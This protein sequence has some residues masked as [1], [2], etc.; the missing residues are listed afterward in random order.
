MKY[1]PF[2]QNKVSDIYEDKNYI[3][4]KKDKLKIIKYNKKNI[5]LENAR[6]NGLF[7]SIVMNNENIV[8]F[9]PQ[10]SVNY[11]NFIVEN[12]FEDC[13]ITEYID[14]TMINIF[15]NYEKMDE[16]DELTPGW[17]FC[18]KSNIGAKCRY[19]LD[20]QKTFYEMFLEACIEEKLDFDILNKKCSYSFVLQHPENR[21][22]KNVEKP[23]LFLTRVFSFNDDND[24]FDVT[25]EEKNI[26]IDTP[27]TFFNINKNQTFHISNWIDFTDL[28]SG[29]DLPYDMVGFVIYN[30][31][32][33]RT[34][35]RNI[36]YE[37]LKR[38]KGNLQKMFLQYLTLRKNNQL[39]YFLK[40]FPEYSAE[41]EIYKKKL[42]NWTYQLFDHYVDT[43]ILKKKR[44]KECPFEFKPILYNIQ[45]EYL[46]MLKP[47]NRKVTFKYISSYV[48]ECIPPKKL[49]FCINYPLRKKLLEKV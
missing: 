37:N 46:E 17:E 35:I 9:A 6:T 23:K 20:T 11:N 31:D 10:K 48:K 43:F 27:R 28:C 24:I 33:V 32:G 13:E 38:L 49:M 30:K 5:T 25:E 21:I 16:N 18:T 40:F 29:E 41:F 14:G 36:A 26:D 12:E 2:K 7:R 34:K 22:V 42:Y 47:N 1:T 44:L 39:S 3:I 15:Y 45:K 19:N 4:K 8:S